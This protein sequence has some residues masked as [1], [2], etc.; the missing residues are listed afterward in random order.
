MFHVFD[1]VLCRTRVVNVR[2]GELYDVYIGRQ[3]RFPPFRRSKWANPF[4]IGPDGDRDQVIDQYAERFLYRPDLLADLHELRGKRLACWCH[5]LAC[6][7]DV[8]AKL[9]DQ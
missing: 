5:P 6:H 2:S 7:G 4:R 8:L 3:N 1:A 9:A